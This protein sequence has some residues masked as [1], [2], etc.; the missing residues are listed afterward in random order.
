MGTLLQDLR[1]GLRMLRKNPGFTAVAVLSL[2]LGIGAN[3]AIFQLLDAVRLRAIPVKDP[4]DLALVQLADRTGWRGSQASSYPALTHPLWARFRDRQ[5]AFSGVLAWAN[6]G[7]NLAPGGEVRLARGL[8]VSGDFFRVLEVPALLGRVFSAADDRPGCGLPG[9]V[10]SRAFWQREF[11]GDPSAIG[12]TLKLNDHPV[13]VIGVTPP[14]FTGLEVGHAY[15]VAVPI[16]SQA[17]LWSEGNW[18][19]QGTVWWLTV[20]G[21]RKPGWTLEKTNAQLGADSPGIF[22]ATLPAN[23]PPVNVKD[24]LAFKLKAVSAGTGVSWLRDQYGDPLVLLLAT[25]ALVLLI[26]CANLANLMLARATAREDEIAVRLAIGASRA[27]IVRQ[28]MTESLVLA[29][30]GGGLGLLLAGALSQLLLALL[31]TQGNPLFLDLEPDR[32]VLA[33]SMGLATVTCL[34]FGLTPALRATR[35]PAGEAMK[36]SGRTTTASRERFGLRQALVVCQVALSLVL[37]VGALLFSGTLR[38]LLA[39]DAGFRQNGLLITQVDFSR[40]KIP[41]ARRFAFV[42]DLLDRMRT[43]PGVVSAG[44]VGMLP[45]SGSGVD[46]NVWLEGSDPSTRLDSNFSWIGPG[47]LGPMGMTLLYGRDFDDRD[48]ASSLRVAIVNQSFAR[49]FGLGPDP[50]GKRFRREATPS[51]PEQVFE[52]VGLVRDTK[53]YSLREEFRAIA[54]LS[55]TQ[56]SDPDPFTQV[57]IRSTAPLTELISRV[58]STVAEVDPAIGLD[59]RAFETTVREGLLRERLM[60]ALSSFFGGLATLI[61]AMGLYGVMSYLVVR[62]TNE[63]GIRMALGADGRRILGLVMRE[64]AVLLLLGL[65]VGTALALAAARAAGAMLF[66]LQPHDPSTLALGAAL[67]AAVTGAASYLPARRAARLEPMVALR[68]Q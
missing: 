64:S 52:I 28:L 53:Y 11:G 12:R 49:R 59:F 7:F 35:I 43:I 47:Y 48:T 18:L 51:A 55:P 67:L 13:E 19:E 10:I 65:L 50:V 40:A 30:A 14:G 45:L 60:A 62:R 26:A 23:Y 44:E 6:N 24:Y 56:S 54:F 16:C 41:S 25:A 36:G 42:R 39:V 20:M 58:R 46:N 29:G 33:F 21:R 1:Y 63:I 66:G 34:L 2:G 22:Q 9:A 27:R 5:D 4:Q 17:V 32:R 68:D 61:A 57:A 31:G 37:L 3:T 15:E 38:K 8:F